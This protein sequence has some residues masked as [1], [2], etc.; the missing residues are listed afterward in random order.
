MVDDDT[1]VF[2]RHKTKRFQGVGFYYPPLNLNPEYSLKR[3][4]LEQLH[5]TPRMVVDIPLI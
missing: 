3:P 4:S 2:R 1:F 5:G